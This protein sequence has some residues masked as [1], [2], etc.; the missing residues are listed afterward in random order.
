MRLLSPT[1][2]IVSSSNGRSV[3]R[4]MTSR[5][6]ASSSR[7]VSATRSQAAPCRPYETS[8]TS[9]PS[10]ATRAFAERDGVVGLAAPRPSS[11]RGRRLSRKITRFV[12]PDRA[13]FRGPCTCS[14]LLG[15]RPSVPGSARRTIRGCGEC[16][17]QSWTP[18]RSVRGLTIGTVDLS[19]GEVAHLGGVLDDLVRR[20]RSRSS[21][22]SSRRRAAGRAWPCRPRSR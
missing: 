13:C 2:P 17:A 10:R 9:V 21:A 3:R 11:R 12:V 7:S 16:C 19:A 1:R 18:R 14:E 22:S 8:V 15:R 20:R 5:S 4:S 6:I